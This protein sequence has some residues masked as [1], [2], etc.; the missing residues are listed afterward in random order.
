M[1]RRRCYGDGDDDDDRLMT[2]TTKMVAP[3]QAAAAVVTVCFPATANDNLRLR[4][5]SERPRGDLSTGV[6]ADER[7]RW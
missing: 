3:P 2:V 5:T 7:Q 1:R 4:Q 6:V